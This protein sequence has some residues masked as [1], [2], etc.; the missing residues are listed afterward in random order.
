MPLPEVKQVIGRLIQANVTV[1]L[2]LLFHAGLWWRVC[3]EHA[4]GRLA[5][6]GTLET[7]TVHP[8]VHHASKQ[9]GTKSTSSGGFPVDVQD[10]GFRKTS[11]TAELNLEQLQ[12]SSIYDGTEG[13]MVAASLVD[14]PAERPA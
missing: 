8:K 12:A 9:D 1:A 3:F 7:S 10:F 2:S 11:K 4:G 5:S 14:A 13:Y 6:S